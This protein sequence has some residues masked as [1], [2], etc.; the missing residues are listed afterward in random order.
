MT[1]T[2]LARRKPAVLD[3]FLY[4][5]LEDKDELLVWLKT[6]RKVGY[7]IYDRVDKV[8]LDTPDWGRLIIKSDYWILHVGRGKFEVL[9]Q[10]EFDSRYDLVGSCE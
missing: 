3:A 5:G 8:V 2:L 4:R 7:G 10:G 1:V 9:T 6:R